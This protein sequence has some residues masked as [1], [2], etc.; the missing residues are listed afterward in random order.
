MKSARTGF[1]TLAAAFKV[2]AFGALAAASLSGCPKSYP[3][4]DD[5]TVCRAKNEVCVE[6]KCRQCRDDAQCTKLDGCMT[7]QANACVKRPGCCKSNI[8][9][10]GGRCW[11]DPRN[12]SAP[13]T[14][15]GMCQQ[16]GDCP[17]GQRCASGSCIPDI[18]CTNDDF[19]PS[20]Q[21]CI[22]GH[23]A[24]I[25]CDPKPVYFDFNEYAIRLDQEATV[26]DNAACLNQRKTERF[27][28]EGHC[29]ERGSD[30]YNLALG[31]RR[32]ATIVRQYQA[33]GVDRTRLGVISYGEEKPV[34]TD[35][36]ETCWGQNR[37]AETLAK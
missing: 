30:E 3:D 21:K 14:C 18:T 8:D 24:P 31:Q 19:C 4:C 11:R 23:C 37:R 1:P 7:C 25:P 34:C 16:N 22:E 26:N 28:T 12:P 33:I 35:S 29:D 27:V 17:S 32:A 36:N 13:G 20:G 5:D 10:P 6:Q 2:L 15:G 9:C